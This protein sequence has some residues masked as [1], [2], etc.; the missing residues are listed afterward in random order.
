MN[1]HSGL[2]RINDKSRFGAQTTLKRQ[3]A[4]EIRHQGLASGPRTKVV[5][6][7]YGGNGRAVPA[8]GPYG[9]YDDQDFEDNCRRSV[10]AG[11]GDGCGSAG[12]PGS[13]SVAGRGVA[14]L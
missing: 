6:P 5:P 10:G 1:I 14:R 8:A 3:T 11:D 9:G 12:D 4:A 7:A 2:V 13:H